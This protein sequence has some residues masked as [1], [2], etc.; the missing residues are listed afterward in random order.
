MLRWWAAVRLGLELSEADPH[1]IRKLILAVFVLGF[2]GLGVFWLVTMPR[3]IA[4]GD[5]PPHTADLANG[6][7]MFWAGGCESCHAA[8]GA[9]G[10]DMLKLGGGLVLAT[11]FGKFHV[12]NISPDPD[13]GIGRGRLPNSSLR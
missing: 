2:A 1:M 11:P 8:P 4:D 13:N 7:T 3:T 6:E 9:T 5:L 12:P 10:D